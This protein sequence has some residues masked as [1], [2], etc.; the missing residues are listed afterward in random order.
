[1]QQGNPPDTAR[2]NARLICAAPALLAALDALVDEQQDIHRP[3][4]QQALKALAMVDL[5]EEPTHV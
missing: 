3:A 1:M 4:Y 2:A 5:E